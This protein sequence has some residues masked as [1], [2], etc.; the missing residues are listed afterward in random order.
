MDVRPRSGRLQQSSASMCTEIVHTNTS[1]QR[2][3][4]VHNTQSDK[5]HALPQMLV[6]L[7]SENDGRLIDG[8]STSKLH[9]SESHV[10]HKSF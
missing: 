9:L 5:T 6:H 1:V 7:T 4:L 2:G 3:N 8:G 10:D